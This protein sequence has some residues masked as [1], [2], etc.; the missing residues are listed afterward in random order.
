MLVRNAYLIFLAMCME[1]IS[2]YYCIILLSPLQ[3]MER[4]GYGQEYINRYKMMTRLV[5]FFLSFG[6]LENIL[7][8]HAL[9]EMGIL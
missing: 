2:V 9:S 1:C 6:I 8:K 4:R 7:G 3:L 5:Y